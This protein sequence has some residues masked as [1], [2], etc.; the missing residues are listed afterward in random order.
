MTQYKDI[1]KRSG[2][3]AVRIVHD[4]KYDQIDLC[5]MR[6]GFQWTGAA[7]DRELLGMIRDAINEF[8]GPTQETSPVQAVCD[9]AA[10]LA[11]VPEPGMH[12]N[13]V[14]ARARMAHGGKWPAE[15]TSGVMFYEGMR[16]TRDD[17]EHR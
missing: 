10:H 9:R 15:L 2:K 5:T 3:K 11:D 8:L 12:R 13:Q 6:N 1:E 7:V 4:T 14:I 16:V 17:F